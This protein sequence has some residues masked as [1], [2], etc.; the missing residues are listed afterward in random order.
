M[1]V[2]ITLIAFTGAVFFLIS[3]MSS[4]MKRPLVQFFLYLAWPLSIVG[5]LVWVMVLN[6]LNKTCWSHKW[7]ETSREGYWVQFTCTKCKKIK[8]EWYNK[9]GETR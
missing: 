6:R 4:E 9:F 8:T 2:L 1:I 5:V 3:A 7:T